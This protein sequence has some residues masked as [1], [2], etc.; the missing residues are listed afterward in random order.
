MK[1]VLNVYIARIT[2]PAHS[3]YTYKYLRELCFLPSVVDLVYVRVN[4][5][6]HVWSG[7]SREGAQWCL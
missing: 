4:R 5:T 7:A 1:C 6:C 3:P 2:F